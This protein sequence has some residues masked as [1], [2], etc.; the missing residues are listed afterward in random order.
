M[1]KKVVGDRSKSAKPAHRNMKDGPSVTAASGS[2][3]AVSF[4]RFAWRYS[5]ADHSARSAG[6]R[7]SEFVENRRSRSRPRSKI[8]I[9]A[10]RSSISIMSAFRSESFMPAASER[11]VTSRTINL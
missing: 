4:I 2:A 9:F 1:A 11:T 6:R 3:P 10:K 7:R 8:F 5:N